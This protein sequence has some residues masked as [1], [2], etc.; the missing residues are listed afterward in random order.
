[1]RLG[2]KGLIIM[3]LDETCLYSKASLAVVQF[4]N[5]N[6]V[7]ACNHLVF[8]P[9]CVNLYITNHV[10]VQCVTDL[11]LTLQQLSFNLLFRSLMLEQNLDVF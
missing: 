11:R 7:Y 6:G 8:F 3:E 2:I 5:L 1:M 9:F 4:Q 10:V